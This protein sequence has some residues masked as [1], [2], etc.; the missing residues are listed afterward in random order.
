M[1]KMKGNINPKKI[2][3]E[4]TENLKGID[5]TQFK[6]GELSNEEIKV[7]KQ[8]LMDMELSVIKLKLNLKMEELYKSNPS[9]GH[10]GLVLSVLE[11]LPI[12]T[13]P[14]LFSIITEYILNEWSKLENKMAA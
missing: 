4:I 2:T 3:K 8:E 11:T 13:S 9:I 12:D 5:F 14:E 6:K 10:K 1:N 7:F